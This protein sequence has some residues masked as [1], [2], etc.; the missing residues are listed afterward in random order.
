LGCALRP[1]PHYLAAVE[2]S[3]SM[4]WTNTDLAGSH[5]S[6][7]RTTLRYGAPFAI[8]ATAWAVW[9]LWPVM[10]QDPFAIFI[11]AVIVCARFFGFGPAVVCTVLC[12][13]TLD[14]AI[15][16][17]FGFAISRN[18]AERLVV[19]VLVCLLTAGLARKRKQAET[20]AGEMRQRM[21]A[22]VE[23]SDDAI[24]SATPSGIVTSWNR[25][26]ESLY[27]YGA[28]E[29]TGRHISFLVPPERTPEL[30]NA[31]AR[32]HR[33]EYVEGYRTEQLRRDASRVMVLVSYSPLRSSTGAVVGFSAIAR[34]VS[35]Q[36]RTEEILRRNE[37]LATAGRMAAT[38]AHEINNPLEAVTNLLYLMREDPKR[39]DEYLRLAERE[40]E[41][42]GAIAQQ[43]LGFVRE[44]SSPVPLNVAET[45]DQVLHLYSRILSCK[46]IQLEKE[47]DSG[48]NIE[49][50]A[51]EL[52]QLFS[53][54]V[55][56]A[57][58]AM[59]DGGTLKIHVSRSRDWADG[60]RPGVRVSIADTGS[61]IRSADMAHLFEP[62]YT[63][64]KDL[65]T[66]LG[67][68]ISYGIV[69][70]HGG[71]VRARSSTR[72]GHSGTVFTVFLP[73]I[74]ETSKAA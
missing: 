14:Y 21:A 50:F 27:G 45:I 57:V 17:P 5:R 69:Q 36:H 61:G 1:R 7:G 51:G 12:A 39:R 32:I 22:I 15:F 26:A 13:L 43:T 68:W 10:H 38:I 40:V 31:I 2:F 56:N 46:H 60:S 11:A 53:N 16:P 35:A 59:D 66:G 62:F 37:K 48:L 44:G 28:S 73:Q 3:S 9:F 41:R 6:W 24:L 42:I 29:A 19:F 8:T 54:L 20:R 70:K 55:I 18:D 23:S 74:L 58:D 30:A 33:A 63:T 47:Y 25:G 65:G 4:A 34:D 49:G 67:L 71:R 64:K 52:R 72:A